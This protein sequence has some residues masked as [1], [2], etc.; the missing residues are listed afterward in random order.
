MKNVLNVPVAYS[1][2]IGMVREIYLGLLLS[3]PLL[4]LVTAL[5]LCGEALLFS[6]LSLSGFFFKI[7][8][9]F[10]LLLMAIISKLLSKQ[11]R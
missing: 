10:L 1:K 6:F 3:L 9:F 2:I 4:E 5:D 8:L 7:F 11:N